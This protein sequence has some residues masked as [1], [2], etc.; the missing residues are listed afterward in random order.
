MTLL[1]ESAEAPD[2]RLPLRDACARSDNELSFEDD[3]A[4]LVSA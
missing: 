2:V 3:I 1:Q 4:Y